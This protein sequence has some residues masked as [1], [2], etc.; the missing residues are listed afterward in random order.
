M[1]VGVIV[2]AVVIPA[3]GSGVR[4]MW[5]IA[6]GCMLNVCRAVVAGTRGAHRRQWLRR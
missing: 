6:F 1:G 5:L 3:V 4:E 2:A